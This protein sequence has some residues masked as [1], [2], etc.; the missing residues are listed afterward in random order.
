LDELGEAEPGDPP[1]ASTMAATIWSNKSLLLKNE[2]ELDESLRFVAG[3]G[4]GSY[5][6]L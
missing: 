5:T 1:K 4:C 3:S 6:R 2:G